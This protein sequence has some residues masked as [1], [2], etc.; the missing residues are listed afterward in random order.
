VSARIL[1]YLNSCQIVDEDDGEFISQLD[2]H[3]SFMIPGAE[4]SRAYKGYINSRGEEVTW[5]GRRHLLTSSLKFSAGL[6]ER[7]ENFYYD[8]CKLVEVCD[9]RPE[10]VAGESTDI[11][12]IL[13]S[14]GKIPYPYQTEAVK[15]A[16]GRSRG[17]IRIA[18]G[19]GKTIVAAMLTAELGKT[20][21]VYVIGRDLLYQI[22]AMFTS[23]FDDEIGIVG[24]GK[25]E[26]R[27]INVATIWSVGQALGMKQG[28]TL[29]D[30]SDK[31]KKIDPAKFR[32][33]KQMLLDTKVH[34]LDECH[35][36]AC[37]TVQ[38]IAQHIKP[39]HVYG[40]SASPWRDDNADLLIEGF[41]GNKIVDI[42]AKYLID[43]GY[44]VKPIIRFLSV[45]PKKYS[46]LTYKTIYSK[47]ITENDHRNKMIAHG[48]E[49]L[50]E[51]G[52]QTLV[53]FHTIKHG[54]QL[55]RDI[56]PRISCALLSG[57]DTS[58]QRNKVK[59]QL[60]DGQ[61]NCIVASKIF[62]IGIDLPSLSGLIV[63]GGGKSSVRAL[64]RIGRVIRKYPG[65]VQSAVIDF[66][67]QTKYLMNHSKIRRNIYSEEFDV[68]WPDEKGK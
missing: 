29:D 24:D 48:A 8:K 51:Q 40:M 63:A 32:I 52:Y 23:L 16:K 13:K 65:K 45:P 12:P 10:F 34:I 11:L 21:T 60:E 53:L 14:Q 36:A 38:T 18:T 68:S 4:H 37:E 49:K 59:E 22:H 67:D 58:K 66:A 39:E 55:Y 30:E 15:I 50:V 54:E 43:E 41:L 28:I 3:L 17:I 7:V 47:Y 6:L 19:G 9:K 62:D 56:S 64:Q 33:I 31:E 42:S 44:L 25:C 26:I 61:L 20:T 57:K 27:D 2:R 35:L 1:R 46:N 5:D